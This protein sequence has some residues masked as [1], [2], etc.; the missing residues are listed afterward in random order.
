M[1]YGLRALNGKIYVY[2]D[3]SYFRFS[4]TRVIFNS[5]IYIWVIWIMYMI[6]KI[7]DVHHNLQFSRDYG[8]YVQCLN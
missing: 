4:K 2:Y 6:F 7:D 3:N 5:Q 8:D 1:D